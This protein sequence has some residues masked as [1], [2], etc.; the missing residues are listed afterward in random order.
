MY[1]YRVFSH[2]RLYLNPNNFFSLFCILLKSTKEE[3]KSQL[4]KQSNVNQ[5]KCASATFL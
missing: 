4:G 3:G 5:D 2:L 1:I